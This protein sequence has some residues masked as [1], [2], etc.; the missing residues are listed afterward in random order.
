MKLKEDIL[1]NIDLLNNNC[2]SICLEDFKEG[3]IACILS[4][5]HIFHKDCLIPWLKKNNNCPN[6]RLIENVNINN[7]VKKNILRIKKDICVGG[8]YYLNI[9]IID[10]LDNK[11]LKILL[12]RYDINFN[13]CL[14]KNDFLNL[15]KNEIFFENKNIKFLQNYL[16]KH[17]INYEYCLEKSD[18]LKLCRVMR[19]IERLY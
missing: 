7:L 16:K 10:K 3:D 13:Y 8:K 6:C 12:R 5:Y 17:N 14:E 18:L 2:C 19:I 9:D 1:F 11:K 15:I 4:C